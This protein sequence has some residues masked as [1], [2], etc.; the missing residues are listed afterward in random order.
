[1]QIRSILIYA[2]S[3]RPLSS[4]LPGDAGVITAVHGDE[5]LGKRLTALGFSIGRPLQL[6]RQARWRGPLHVRLGTTDVALRPAE[7]DGIAI[8]LAEPEGA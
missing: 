4:L 6:L 5:T 8:R 2:M 7:A 1:M 3:S